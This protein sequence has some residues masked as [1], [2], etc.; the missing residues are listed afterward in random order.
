MRPSPCKTFIRLRLIVESRIRRALSDH[1]C[2]T[3]R[4]WNRC[5]VLSVGAFARKGLSNRFSGNHTFSI[6]FA[7]CS[8]HCRFLGTFHLKFSLEPVVLT[9]SIFASSV[10]LIDIVFVAPNLGTQRMNIKTPCSTRVGIFTF[11]VELLKMQ[12]FDRA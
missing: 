11:F 8:A 6:G 9:F 5:L 10:C 7:G 2:V 3:S 1:Y 12:K 4:P